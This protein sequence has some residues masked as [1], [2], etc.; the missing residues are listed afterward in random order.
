ML[1]PKDWTSWPFSM[2]ALAQTPLVVPQ[3]SSRIMTSWLT[4]TRRRGQVAGVGGTQGGIC[5]ALARASAGDEVLQDGEALTE[6][7][8]DGYL[9]GL[10][11]GVSHQA[12]HTGQLADLVHGATGAGVRHH[13]DGVELV[14][15]VLQRAGD[16][17]GGLLPLIDDQAV[18]FV[19]GDKAAA[20]LL[21]DVQHLVLGVL[22]EGSA[23][24]RAR[25]YPLWIW[26][27]RRWWNTCSR[28]P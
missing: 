19:V 22:D 8:L 9:D 26:S 14:Q 15:A 17:L 7:G 24:R 10:A 28:A 5:Q 2:T 11:G 25:S 12:A 16:I 13:V 3:S 6:V 18:A 20:E 4:S 21:F 1:T 23:W 27:A